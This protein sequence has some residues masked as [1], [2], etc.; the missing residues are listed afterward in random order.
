MTN[1]VVNFN[2][3]DEE[4]NPSA[5]LL[6]KK[7][8]IDGK[9]NASTNTFN[10]LGIHDDNTEETIKANY[11]TWKQDYLDNY[12]DPMISRMKLKSSARSKLIAGEPLTE[13]E[14]ATIVP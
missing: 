5:V 2:I 7:I 8:R 4:V 12:E 6:W 13:E 3:V 11:P 10:V 14:A 1:K 9:Y